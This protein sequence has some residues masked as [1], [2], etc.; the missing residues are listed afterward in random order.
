MKNT[1]S[2]TPKTMMALDKVLIIIINTLNI[3]ESSENFQS[4]SSLKVC[5]QNYQLSSINMKTNL[6]QVK[7]H[8]NLGTIPV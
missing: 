3:Y 8:E 1:K 5:K 4:H 2:L 7:S 6:Q